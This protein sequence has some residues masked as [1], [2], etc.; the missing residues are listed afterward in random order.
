MQAME[1]NQLKENFFEAI[2]KEWMIVCAGGADHY[3]MMTASW[4]GI[5]WL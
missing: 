2:S 3:N 1:A 4:G 5:G